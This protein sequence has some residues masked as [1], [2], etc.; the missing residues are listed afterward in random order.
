M[1][2]FIEF[3]LCG[4]LDGMVCIDIMEVIY[5]KKR[6]ENETYVVLKNN[7]DFHLKEKYEDIILRLKT[8]NR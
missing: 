8:L 1:K 4:A 5:F 6:N 3:K 2:Q 7:I